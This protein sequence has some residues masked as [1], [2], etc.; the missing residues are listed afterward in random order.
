MIPRACVASPGPWLEGMW[1]GCAG[2][3]GGP[4]PSPADHWEQPQTE[5]SPETHLNFIPEGNG[6]FVPKK[7]SGLDRET[8]MLRHWRYSHIPGGFQPGNLIFAVQVYW[9]KLGVNLSDIWK[10]GFLCIRTSEISISSDKL[11]MMFRYFWKLE[12]TGWEAP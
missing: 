11:I 9:S 7:R 12:N 10:T 2:K 6:W 5:S 1:E 4:T 3:N 8:E